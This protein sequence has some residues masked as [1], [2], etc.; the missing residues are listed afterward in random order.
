MDINQAKLAI[1]DKFDTEWGAATPVD[2][3]N[4]DFDE[5]QGTPWARM[6]VRTQ[7]S[8][9][10]SL[11]KVG[12]RKYLRKGIVFVQIFVPVK[13]GTY[14]ADV[15]ADRVR[16]IFEGTRLSGIWFYETDVSE[17]GEDGKYFTYLVQSLFNYEQVK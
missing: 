15:L 10:D 13:T 7:P 3:D 8:N 5:P 1:R 12:N 11:G 14:D 6:V 9:Q 16:T 4:D 2:Y 17:Q